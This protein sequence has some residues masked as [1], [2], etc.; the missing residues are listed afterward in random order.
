MYTLF[1][2]NS[3]LLYNHININNYTVSVLHTFIIVGLLCFFLINCVTIRSNLVRGIDYIFSLNNIVVV[4]PY[5]FFT[6]T[7]FTFLFVL[8]VVSVIVFYNLISSKI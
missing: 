3:I 4:L 7:V 6:N 5:L 2:T 8:E 1:G